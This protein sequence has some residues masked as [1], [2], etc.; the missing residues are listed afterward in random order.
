MELEKRVENLE[1][2]LN[3]VKK[4]KKYFKKFMKFIFCK[5][6]KLQNI[7][8]VDNLEEINTLNEKI[9]NLNLEV[10]EL[11][12]KLEEKDNK[13]KSLNKTIFELKE[14]PINNIFNLY[15]NLSDETKEGLSNIFSGNDEFSLL[16]SGIINFDEVWEY[17]KYLNDENEKEDFEILR[18]IVEKLFEMIKDNQNLEKQNIRILQPFDMEIMD[19]DNKSLSQSGEVKEIILFG[20]T[21][22]NE[23]V[24][25]SVVRIG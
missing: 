22:N 8:K 13:I 10:K 24:N 20:Y 14:N 6:K 7:E 3:K 17:A 21:K 11:E 19:R 12:Y 18:K 23:I 1:K 25:K 9:K 15:Q 4:Q 5:E 2:E 16:S